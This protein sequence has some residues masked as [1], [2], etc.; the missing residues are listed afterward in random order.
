MRAAFVNSL[1]LIV[2]PLIVFHCGV[3][4]F[5]VYKKVRLAPRRTVAVAPLQH[6]HNNNLLAAVMEMK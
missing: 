6:L 4:F 3:F 1:P 2:L 5:S